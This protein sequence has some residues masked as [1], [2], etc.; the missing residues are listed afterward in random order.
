MMAF[1][2]VATGVHMLA[3]VE[4]SL[5]QLTIGASE[6]AITR[7]IFLVMK[8]LLLYCCLSLVLVKCFLPG[9]L[10][11]DIH[12]LTFSVLFVAHKGG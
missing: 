2:V 12:H 1:L 5:T 9:P 4:V 7:P 11:R 3:K 6:M 8:S 10:Y